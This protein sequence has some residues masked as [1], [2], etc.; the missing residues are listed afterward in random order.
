[1]KT[2]RCIYLFPFSVFYVTELWK[3]VNSWCL[4]LHCVLHSLK[5]TV[6]NTLFYHQTVNHYFIDKYF[7]LS[8]DVIASI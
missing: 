2:R 7:C 4:Y 6:L 3:G 8:T 5:V 1:M